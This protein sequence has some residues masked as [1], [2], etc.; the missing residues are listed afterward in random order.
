MNSKQLLDQLGTQLGATA[1]SIAVHNGLALELEPGLHLD[2]YVTDPAT[3]VHCCLALGILAGEFKGKLLR[4]LL[5]AN[6]DPTVLAGGHFALDVPEGEVL[7]ARNLPT[8]DHT[9]V[10]AAAQV[11]ALITVARD[12]RSRLLATGLLLR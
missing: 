6:L 5:T 4:T 3:S 11:E 7:L 2:I 10:S 12:W 8:R 1:E 9:A